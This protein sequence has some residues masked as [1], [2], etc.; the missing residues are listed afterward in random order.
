MIFLSSIFNIGI[1][2]AITRGV[3][4]SFVLLTVSVNFR[5]FQQ[6]DS[7]ACY[8]YNRLAGYIMAEFTLFSFLG[9][10]AT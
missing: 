5:S 1:P 4:N 3:N 7:F 10:S 2:D 9:Y 8:F 6:F